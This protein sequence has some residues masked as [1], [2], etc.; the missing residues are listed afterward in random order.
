[1]YHSLGRFSM[2]G[3]MC[4]ASSC[5]RC[6]SKCA[7]A[8]RGFPQASSQAASAKPRQLLRAEGLLEGFAH[9]VRRILRRHLPNPEF[10]SRIRGGV[11]VPPGLLPTQK[12]ANTSSKSQKRAAYSGADSIEID[13]DLAELIDAWPSLSSTNRQA[14]LALLRRLTTSGDTDRGLARSS[15]QTPVTPL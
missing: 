1:V 4:S 9:P 8:I 2:I 14:L 11:V 6:V 15:T 10:L 7:S 3:P 13:A 12:S 5:P